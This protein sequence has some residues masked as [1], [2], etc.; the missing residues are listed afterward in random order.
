MTFSVVLHTMILPAL[1]GLVVGFF[2]GVFAGIVVALR[3]ID[4][5]R[6]Q[7]KPMPT[8]TED[9][10]P[11]ADHRP[12]QGRREHLTWLGIFLA[13]VGPIALIASIVGI[14]QNNNTARCV[15]DFNAAFAT[16]Q[17]ERADAA[18]LDRRAIRQQRAVTREFNAS[19]IE[20]I[21]HPVTDPAG[22]EKARAEFL[23]KVRAWDDRLAEVDQLD[24][25][26]EQ[27]RRQ[28]P[29]PTQPEC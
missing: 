27:Q 24:G 8:Y 20:A 15:A 12:W 14:V 21:S 5:R 16:A 26:A 22:M 6:T 3:W 10:F 4:Q 17:R 7:G 23:V 25:A 13:V 29:L 18:E 2:A 28:N 19:M 1:A 9:D 11:D